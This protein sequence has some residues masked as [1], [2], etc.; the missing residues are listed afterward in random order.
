MATP[1][2]PKLMLYSLRCCLDNSNQW[3]VSQQAHQDLID[4][5]SRVSAQAPRRSSESSKRGYEEDRGRNVGSNLS[6]LVSSMLV[7]K[8]TH[9]QTVAPYHL[10]YGRA[11][12]P[13]ILPIT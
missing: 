1:Y 13:V 9:A 12:A 6:D 10:R 5:Q 4:G 8:L 2:A 3:T 11:L 7:T